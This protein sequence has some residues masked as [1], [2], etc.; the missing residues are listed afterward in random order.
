MKRIRK[1]EGRGGEGGGGAMGKGE[2]F[3]TSLP[4]FQSFELCYIKLFVQN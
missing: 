2:R 3:Q 4:I 1:G